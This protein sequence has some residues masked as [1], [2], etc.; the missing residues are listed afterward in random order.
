[1]SAKIVLILFSWLVTTLCN[2]CFRVSVC[3]HLP[4]FQRLLAFRS[5]WWLDIM[6]KLCTDENSFPDI[7]NVSFLLILYVSVGS[8]DASRNFCSHSKEI[9][10]IRL[11]SARFDRIS[12]R[13]VL[14]SAEV[15]MRYHGIY[16]KVVILWLMTK[17]SFIY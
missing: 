9:V 3:W 12:N 13:F 10:M 8:R 14:N 6:D 16:Q 11:C 17:K 5:C 4:F 2:S 7:I 1:M 15:Q